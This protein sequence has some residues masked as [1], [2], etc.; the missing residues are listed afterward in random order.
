VL[1]GPPGAGKGT[2]AKIITDKF[3][4]PGV[5]TGEIFRENLS[6]NTQLGLLAKE[7]LNKGEL[8]PDDVTI[9]MVRDYLEQPFYANG[10][11]LDGFPRTLEQAEALIEMAHEFN[12]QLKVVF[13]KVPEQT[14]VERIGGR[15]I[16]RACH[17]VFNEIFNPPPNPQECEYGGNCD[18]FQRDDDKVEIVTNRIKIYHEQTMPLLKFFDQKGIL[19]VIDGTLPIDQVTSAVLGALL[20]PAG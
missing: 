2:Q 9:R 19:R 17:R 14:L 13:I 5:A 6:N 18:L 1:F 7:Y 3:G 10:V 15:V 8:V 16:C 11:I 12:A 20:E 4:L